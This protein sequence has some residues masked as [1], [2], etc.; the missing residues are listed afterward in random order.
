[1]TSNLTKKL[2]T[3]M[4]LLMFI[5]DFLPQKAFKPIT[6]QGN[7]KM[8]DYPLLAMFCTMCVRL[9]ELFVQVSN[10]KLKL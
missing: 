4:N 5:S 3:L 10:N 7:V 9:A 1:M 8:Y 2:L 6:W